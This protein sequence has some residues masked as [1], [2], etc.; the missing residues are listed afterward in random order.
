MKRLSD[1]VS[2]LSEFEA[3]RRVMKSNVGIRGVAEKA[4]V[5]VGTVS[6]VLNHPD[7]VSPKNV[8]KVRDTMAALG[9][10]R[11]D[12]AR[13]L[14][15]GGG[16]AIGLVVVNV[17]NPF[18]ADLAHAL[19]AAAENVGRTIVIGSSDQDNAREDRYIDLF[20]EQRVRGLLIAPLNGLTP[21]LSR[22]Q[23]TG[24]P[25]VLFDSNIE[26]ELVCSVG[27]DGTAGG[28]LAA[29]HLIET[30]RR[31]IMFAGGP[32]GQVAERF[33]GASRAA[34][35]TPGVTLTM[36]ETH[37]LTVADSVFAANDLLAIGILQELILARNVSV[38]S[39]IAIIGYDDIDFATSTMVPLSTIRQPREL[40]ATIALQILE[41]EATSAGDHRHGR[42]L[43][44]PELIVRE[45]TAPRQQ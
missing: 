44:Q 45:S 19:E 29:S 37:D 40:L 33:T 34:Q 41:E 3:N 10:V 42:R 11:N 16:D 9:F 23:G 4:G 8:K 5:S 13:Q 27:L 43:L 7:E 12:L 6:K 18:W 2:S 1:I 24:T 22:L 14:R 15:M 36:F 20:E 21:R 25:L 26:S 28:H 30:G 39:D 35:E 17:G 32:F 31:R 38:P